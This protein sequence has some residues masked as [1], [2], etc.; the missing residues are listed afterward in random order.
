M[1]YET[2]TLSKKNLER[3]IDEALDK[4]IEFS[5]LETYSIFLFNIHLKQ[6]YLDL[7]LDE[8]NEQRDLG[9]ND[10]LS[11]YYA[12]TITIDKMTENYLDG[13]VYSV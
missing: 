7:I 10:A 5:F 9:V 8:Y 1:K 6:K 11:R 2:P 4:K 13:K 3:L 12:L